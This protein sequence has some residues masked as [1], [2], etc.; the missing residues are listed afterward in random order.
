[1]FYRVLGSALR[2]ARVRKGISLKTLGQALGGMTAATVSGIEKG[3][4]KVGAHQLV[5]F[6]SALGLDLGTFLNDA[7]STMLDGYS[8]PI[9]FTP[10][11]DNQPI[12][13]LNL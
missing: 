13:L 4:Q 10:K 12:D 3:R 7:A 11:D 6:A 1:M 8:E 5:L 9:S 2:A